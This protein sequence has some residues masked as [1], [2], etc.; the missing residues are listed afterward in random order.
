L[1]AGLR[2]ARRITTACWRC[3][4][5][6]L[7]R[8]RRRRSCQVGQCRVKKGHRKGGLFQSFGFI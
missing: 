1:A 8:R 5:T 4:G 2:L 7:H 3:T 6:A